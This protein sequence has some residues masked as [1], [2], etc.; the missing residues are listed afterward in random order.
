[1][2]NIL[3]PP[4]NIP[5]TLFETISLF[6]DFSADDMQYGDM[7][8]QDFLSL[9]L[10]DISAKVDPYR[11]IKYHFPGPGSINV[12]FS[13]SSSGTKISQRECTDILFA[14]M[15][16]LAKMLSF[17]GQYK[18]L[19]EDLIEHFRYGNGS[20]FHSQQLNLSFH[21]KINKYGYNSPIRIIKECIENGINSTPSTG[22][23]P[24]I[25]Q[26]IKT[27][28]LS[29]RLNKFNDF[30][31]SFF[32]GLGISVHDISAQKISLL[33]FQKYAIGWSATIH[34]VAQDHFGLDVTDIKNK[35]YSKYRFFRIWFFL[36]RHKD[37]AF[38]PFFTNFN[39]IERIENYL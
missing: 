30:E 34:F 24:L 10:S 14:E 23:Q 26:S 31:D 11:L 3:L 35:T 25:L 17:F 4:I 37:F 9:G 16:E 36:Q 22:Y 6:D 28:L 2:N 21:E 32:N 15:K 18:T 13:A 39:T 19:I 12:A 20:N 7:V 33:S 8:E 1:M 29:S 38:K 27:K 5:C